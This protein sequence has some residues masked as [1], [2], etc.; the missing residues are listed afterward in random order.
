GHSRRVDPVPAAE[1]SFA[2]LTPEAAR[3]ELP[4]T[5][6]ALV[7]GNAALPHMHELAAGA[8]P[9]QLAEQALEERTAAPAQPAEVDHPYGFAHPRLQLYGSG[10]TASPG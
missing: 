5:A 10:V 4:A 8:D 7:L 3:T 2:D 6:A 9:G 1:R